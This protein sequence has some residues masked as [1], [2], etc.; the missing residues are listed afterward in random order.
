MWIPGD[1]DDDDEESSPVEA[2]VAAASPVVQQ[3]A[4]APAIPAAVQADLNAIP[5]AEQAADEASEND[6]N[7]YEDE[8]TADVVP[9]GQAVAT[10]QEASAEGADSIASPVVSNQTPAAAAPAS[11]EDDDDDEDDD[12][13]VDL[14]ITEDDDEDDENDDDDDD[15]DDDDDVVGDIADARQAREFKGKTKK[16]INTRKHA[17]K[18]ASHSLSN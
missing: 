4:P 2:P 18:S 14:D 6:T 12:D 1:E 8:E 16:H 5:A 9:E 11:S 17:R 10:I 13:V 7:T 15:E 3:A